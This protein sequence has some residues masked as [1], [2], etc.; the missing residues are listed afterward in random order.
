MATDT[1]L[2]NEQDAIIRAEVDRSLRHPVMFFFTSGAVWLAIS[3]FFG[4][5]A[6]IK[7]HDP[8]FGLL[9]DFFKDSSLFAVGRAYAAHMNVLLYG[10]GAQAAF[11][12]M[13]WLMA[14]LTR[15]PSRNSG[16]ILTAGHLWNLAIAVGLIGICTGKGTGVSWMEFPTC[17]WPVLLLSYVLIAVWSLV[18]FQV[19]DGSRTFISQWYLMAAML[20]FPWVFLSSHLFVF[21]FEGHPLMTAG[22]NAW[23]KATLVF[24]FFI[25]V[26]VGAAYY[27]TPK[28]TGRAIYSYKLAIFGFW[29][30]AVIGPWAGMQKLAGAPIPHFLPYM[31]MVAMILFMIPAITVGVNILVTMKKAPEVLPYSPTLRFVAAGSILLVV[32]GAI[33]I[34]L[35]TPNGLRETQ[36]SIAGYGYEILAIY[37]VFSMIIFGAIYFIVPRITVREWLSSRFINWHFWLSVYGVVTIVFCSIFGG[38]LQG[39]AQEAF[40]KPWMD[41]ATRGYAYTL[42]TTIA[43]HFIFVSN[44]VFLLHL[45][46]M[47]MRLGRRSQ[48]PTL[49]H[50]HHAESPHGGEGFVDNA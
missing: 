32:L 6:S 27:L 44:L 45:L 30:L 39:E 19:R 17:V 33:G 4:M 1:N 14:R 22:V 2:S 23:F 21:V 37:G 43:W 8:D 29:A 10:W 13:I 34:A 9:P 15:Q 38:F 28:V 25:P 12:V 46:L 35:N 50:S 26:A 31:G 11:G 48:H 36:F 3:I 42:G 41:A 20:W 24:L 7:Q 40:D 49:L 18:Q 16:V 47:W 5:I